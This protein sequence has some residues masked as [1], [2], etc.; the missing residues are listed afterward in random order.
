MSK[1]FVVRKIVLLS[2]VFV[3]LKDLRSFHM[4]PFNFAS[5]DELSF[6]L[7]N[8]IQEFSVAANVSASF[9]DTTSL[10]RVLND[11]PQ[12]ATLVVLTEQLTASSTFF[13][14]ISALELANSTWLFPMAIKTASL[15]SD[16]APDSESKVLHYSP[17]D[18]KV[19][20]VIPE[21]RFDS[22]V[23]VLTTD[24]SNVRTTAFY[25]VR[26]IETV[27]ILLSGLVGTL[28]DL[29]SKG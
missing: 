25:V 7:V 13:S 20:P 6:E 12:N 19:L 8:I 24:Q 15:V 29:P 10:P 26:L 4:E 16:L 2:T 1:E 17:L 3:T 14:G 27:L 21:L 5:Q 9:A 11:G 28:R 23:F 22:K 18:P